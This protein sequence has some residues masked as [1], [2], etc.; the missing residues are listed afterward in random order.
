MD[1]ILLTLELIFIKGLGSST[2]KKLIQ[3]Y[4]TFISAVNQSYEEIER[5][6]G[7]NVAD[8]IIK[9]DKSLR[10]L[11]LKEYEKAAKNNVRLIPLSSKEYPSLLKEI[12]DPPVVL[13]LKGILKDLDNSISVVGTRKYSQYGM[14]IVNNIVRELAKNKVTIVSG[15]ALGIDG[16]SHKV[17]LE[18]DSYTIAVVGNSLD[19]IYPPENKKL[20]REIEE[21]GCII[22]EFPFGT[23]PSMYTF[24]RRNRIIAGLSYGTF[25]VE[26]PEK[27]GSLITANYAN[28]YGR[29]VFT[30]PA[31]INLKSASGNNLLIKEGAVPI[32]NFEDFKQYLPY[33]NYNQTKEESLN[34]STEEL[35]LLKVI[36]N[37]KVYIDTILERFNNTNVYE[38]LNQLVIKGL[39]NEEFGF[40]YRI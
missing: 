30:V 11:A 1:E 12:N 15:L 35:E 13:Y 21:K 9:R 26:A 22:S 17:A 23:K 25:V 18:E 14:Y 24:P 20:Y 4:Q 16:L 7:G 28:D 8:L 19:F 33:L 3:H 5:N 34:L 39:L 40:Y 6:F 10:D 31:N 32:T 2:V 37:E 38:I 27:S 29:L 36:G